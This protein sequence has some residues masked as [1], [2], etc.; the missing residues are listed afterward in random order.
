MPDTTFTGAL[1]QFTLYE[2]EVLSETLQD[3]GEIFGDDA[4]KSI[5][6]AT[7]NASKE[8]REALLANLKSI[9]FSGSALQSLDQIYELSE[10]FGGQYTKLFEDI[11]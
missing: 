11:R 5:Y 1:E 4:A 2:A 8:D 9:D 7:L 3:F 6:N 10:D